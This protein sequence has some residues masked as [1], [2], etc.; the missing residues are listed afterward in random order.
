[1]PGEAKKK[2]KKGKKNAEKE[3]ELEEQRRLAEE[4]AKQA[5]LRAKKEKEMREQKEREALEAMFGKEKER[6]GGEKE[7]VA[8][9]FQ[10][11][12]AELTVIT[13]RMRE[14]NDWKSFVQCSKLPNPQVERDL[15]TFLQLL[16][17][18]APVTADDASLSNLM[19]MLDEIDQRH[20]AIALDRGN[21]VE[22]DRL[23]GHILRLRRITLGKWDAVTVHILQHVDYFHWEANENFQIA[24][25]APNALFGLWGNLTRNPRFKMIE[26]NEIE[27]SASLPKPLALSNVAIR[28]LYE[29]SPTVSML[30]PSEQNT[31]KLHMSIVGGVLFCDL[32][33]L[34]EVPKTVDAWT[35]R[36]VLSPDGQL[37]R[38]TYPFKKPVAEE[39][40]ETA[41]DPT[42]WPTVVTFKIPPGIFIDKASATIMY[43]DE[44]TKSWETDNIADVEIRTDSWQVKFQTIHFKPTALVQKMSHV[45][46]NFV[47]PRSLKG[48]EMEDFILKNP[49]V[50]DIVMMG[51][52]LCA[53][54]FVMRR[55]PQNQ[56]LASSQ[57][58]VLFSEWA[59][60]TDLE[61]LLGSPDRWMSVYFDSNFKT[62]VESYQA[63]FVVNGEIT[64]ATKFDPELLKGSDSLKSDENVSILEGTSAL[65]TYTLLEILRSTRLCCFS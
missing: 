15:N 32:V 44:E 7:E 53:P 9:I 31:K 35:I 23:K 60:E 42:V 58:T 45:G 24:T 55:S 25:T 19:R 62:G 33:E 29:T 47:G 59:Q 28:M 43:Y 6:L 61:S 49:T 63:G 50:E 2:G 13:D 14:E 39:E 1:M 3:K 56:R 46:L 34:P 48:V 5:E 11:I 51:M 41:A 4:E 17:D 10:R 18:E 57:C 27:M 30:F 26:F 20:M 65:F 37:K 22:A 12:E 8:Q 21:N 64:E 16:E 40:Q 52:A 36:P 38:I 54:T